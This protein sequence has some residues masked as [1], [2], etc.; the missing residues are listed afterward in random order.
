[1]SAEE[2]GKRNIWLRALV[3]VLI[4]R[5]LPPGRIYITVRHLGREQ[6]RRSHGDG[7]M[8]AWNP[9]CQFLGTR[10]GSTQR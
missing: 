5:V 1:M 7:L 4:V 8:Y 10:K 3:I 6:I 9:L 2:R